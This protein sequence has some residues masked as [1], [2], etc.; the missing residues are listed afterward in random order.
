MIVNFI[1]TKKSGAPVNK[2]TTHPLEIG[3]L[4]VYFFNIPFSTNATLAGRS[5]RRR[6]K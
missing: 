2:K 1:T 6:I 5:A 3:S 4:S